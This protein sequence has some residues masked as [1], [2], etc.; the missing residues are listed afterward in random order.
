VVVV[1]VYLDKEKGPLNPFRIR[2][3]WFGLY[4]FTRLTLRLPHPLWHK[5]LRKTLA[6]MRVAM[7]FA[8]QRHG[9]LNGH[10]RSR[11]LLLPELILPVRT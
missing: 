2:G 7:M 8:L 3:P 5:K 10:E 4:R 11:Q 6:L 1:L 9:L